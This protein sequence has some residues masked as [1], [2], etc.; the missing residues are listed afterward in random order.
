MKAKQKLLLFYLKTG[1]GH[2]ACAT[3]VSD[4]LLKKHGKEVEIVMCDALEESPRLKKFMLE[5]S[6]RIS[7]NY[8]EW[9]FELTYDINENPKVWK[10][11]RKFVD[12]LFG[13]YIEKKILEEKPDKIITFHAFIIK[14]AEKV[15]KKNNL[16]IPI[17]AVVTDPFRTPRPWFVSKNVH[18]ILSTELSLKM[19]LGEGIPRSRCTICPTYMLNPKYCRRLPEAEVAKLKRKFGLSSSKKIILV[20]GGGDGIPKG[21]TIV[22]T[23]LGKEVDAE[24][25]LVCGR[26]RQLY[27]LSGLLARR[28]SNLHVYGFVDFVYELL[29]M[30]DVVITKCGASVIMEILLQEKIPIINSYLG[31]QEKSNMEFVVKNKVGFC[32]T[33][34]SRLPALISKI[35]ESRTIY[36]EFK[37]RLGKLALKNSTPEVAEHILSIK[38]AAKASAKKASKKEKRK[39]SVQKKKKGPKAKSR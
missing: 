32:E 15:L 2:K 27:Q 28:H 37:K 3:S 12:T 9:L 39:P 20:L 14:P 7:Q 13:D 18:Y 35:F 11:T 34:V 6:Y 24:I 38:Y 1:G 10:Q 4:Y 22:S 23:L 26:N 30:S 16:S 21:L 19:A 31:N 33:R 17:I 25:L 36:P 8:A 29:N 5:D